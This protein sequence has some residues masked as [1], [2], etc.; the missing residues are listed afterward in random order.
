MGISAIRSGPAA[1]V[2][3]QFSSI[4]SLFR[5]PACCFKCPRVHVATES[6]TEQTIDRSVSHLRAHFVD[7][8]GE[9]DA[10]LFQCGDKPRWS[11]QSAFYGEVAPYLVDGIIPLGHYNNTKAKI[12]ANFVQRS[13]A[14]HNFNP[15]LLQFISQ[16]NASLAPTAPQLPNLGQV[17]F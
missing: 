10:I 17:S 13:I 6:E 11:L 7:S 16:K 2:K 4:L 14:A 5:L 12:H 8:A 9:N 1:H 15:V 3:I